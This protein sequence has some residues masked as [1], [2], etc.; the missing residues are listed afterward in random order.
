MADN[1]KTYEYFIGL[2]FGDLTLP[3]MWEVRRGIDAGYLRI[4]AGI[5]RA[6]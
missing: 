1:S 3:D 6:A 5:V 2:K 4:Y